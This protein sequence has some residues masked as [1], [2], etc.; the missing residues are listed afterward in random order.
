[1]KKNNC[2]HNCKISM[3]QYE[4]DVKQYNYY[5]NPMPYQMQKKL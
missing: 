3:T 4:Q 1:M 5:V 2:N